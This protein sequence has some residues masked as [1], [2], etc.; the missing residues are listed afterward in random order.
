VDAVKKPTWKQVGFFM[1]A[2]TDVTKENTGQALFV[3][4]S[5]YDGSFPLDASCRSPQW[6]I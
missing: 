5:Q 3:D 2:S 6:R 1:S 4:N